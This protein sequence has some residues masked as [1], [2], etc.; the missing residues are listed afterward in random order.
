M[1]VDE[2]GL[3]G[4]DPTIEVGREQLGRRVAIGLADQK[5]TPRGLREAA[6]ARSRWGRPARCDPATAGDGICSSMTLG[7][8]RKFPLLA[9]VIAQPGP[10]SAEP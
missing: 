6:V 1:P 5:N 3:G 9:E 7:I 8:N 4:L 10:G 2:L